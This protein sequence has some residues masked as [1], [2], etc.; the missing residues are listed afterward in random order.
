MLMRTLAVVA[1]I[2]EIFIVGASPAR[3]EDFSGHWH[4]VFYGRCVNSAVNRDACAA[5]Q[6]PARFAVFGH[7]G[8]V[9]TVRGV[10][11]YTSDRAGRYTVRFWTTV[12]ESVPGAGRPERCTDALVFDGAFSG[13]CRETGSGRGHIALGR[14]GM[15]DFWQDV[16]R[17]VWEGAPPIPFVTTDPTDTFNPACPGRLNV[18]Q[19]LF[20]LGIHRVP[21]GITGSL[22]LTRRR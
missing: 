19:F 12:T 21:A 15:P 18:K 16:T 9:L 22:L 1:F 8:T 13:T 10:G 20:L 4:L 17:G 3:A 14:T 5:L 2:V 11:D 7:R 6:G